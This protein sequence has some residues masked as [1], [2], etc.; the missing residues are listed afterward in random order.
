VVKSGAM[1]RDAG[2]F[3]SDGGCDRQ[4]GR[5][6]ERSPDQR[7]E[8]DMSHTLRGGGNLRLNSGWRDSSG[9]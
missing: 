5:D 9:S 6:Q 4:G 2:K 3:P 7:L 8:G 1:N